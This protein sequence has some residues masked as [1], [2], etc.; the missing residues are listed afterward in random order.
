M[1]KLIVLLLFLYAFPHGSNAQIY[2]KTDALHWLFVMPN[3]AV[4]TKLAKHFTLSAEILYSPWES[5]NG[6]PLRFIQ[7]NPDVRWYPKAAFNGFYVGVYATIQDFKLSKW[8][9][10]NGGNY[11]DG[12]G[13]GFGAMLGLQIP[14][15]ERWSLD[16]YVGAGWHHGE[17][18]GY[19]KNTGEQYVGKNGSG[20]WIPYR[21]GIVICYRLGKG[22]L[23]NRVT[24]L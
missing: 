14:F 11:Q 2:I 17:Y 9:Y 4:E 5:I 8:N 23:R 1:K 15:S 18:E 13:Y 21:A 19:N 22:G 16:V 20:E 7:L 24:S 3:I 6:N 10:W 12:W